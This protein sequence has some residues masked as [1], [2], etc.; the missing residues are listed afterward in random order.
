MVST[1][2]VCVVLTH[3]IDLFPVRVF[4]TPFSHSTFENRFPVLEH[5]FIS[6]FIGSDEKKR[7]IQTV[8]NIHTENVW[9]Q[10]PQWWYRSF[11]RMID[12]SLHLSHSFSIFILFR[13]HC[14]H[15]FHTKSVHFQCNCFSRPFSV[16]NEFSTQCIVQSGQNVIKKASL[17]NAWKLLIR[18]WFSH[19]CFQNYFINGIKWYSKRF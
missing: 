6:I 1:E 4:N 8:Y 9:I 19:S 5:A 3:N 10:S 12:L 18:F 16:M 15:S 2:S 14:T 7:T 13:T 17:Y 11:N